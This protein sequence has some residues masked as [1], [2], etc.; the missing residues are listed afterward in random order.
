MIHF[1][2]QHYF[3]IKFFHLLSVFAWMAG[4]FYFPRLLVYHCET[5]SEETKRTLD[6]MAS[7]LFK[8][9][10][11]PAMHSSLLF[12]GLLYF[13]PHNQNMGWLHAKLCCI[14]ILIVFQYYM[15]ACSEHL[16]SR[17][18]CYSGK[19]FRILNEVPTLI[20]IFIL[21]LVVYKPF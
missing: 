20:L 9:I 3:L 13:M 8:I 14:L 17:S 1:L 12:G 19:H 16:A 15:K 6:L 21:L 2:T 5:Q 18:R 10:M 11:V 4:L 7:K